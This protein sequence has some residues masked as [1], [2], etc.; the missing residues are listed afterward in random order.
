MKM[1][2][3]SIMNKMIGIYHIISVRFHSIVQELPLI[4]GLGD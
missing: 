4:Q 1:K 2:F 3:N